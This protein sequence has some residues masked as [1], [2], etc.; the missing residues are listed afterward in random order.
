MRRRQF[1]GLS[2]LVAVWPIIA[3]A[4]QAKLPTVGFLVAGAPSSHARFVAAFV[5]RLHELGWTEGRTI[6]MEY[7]W[8]DGS[9]ERA[10]QLAAEF[11]RLKVDLIVTSGIATL[12][13][14][15]VIS[16]TPIVFAVVSDPVGLGLVS[17]LGRPGSNLTGLS[18]Q[19]TDL[20]GKRL[21]ILREVLP[22]LRRLGILA[23][24]G[25]PGPLL[26]IAEVEE[27]ARTLGLEIVAPDL[28]R[29]E[30]LAPAFAALKGRVDALYVVTDPLVNTHLVDISAMTVAARVPTLHGTREHVDAG[31]LLSYGPSL[32]DLYGRA[33]GYVDKILRGAKPGD[34][35]VQ[36]PTKFELV[37]NL[38]TAQ[39]PQ[40]HDSTH[41]PRPRRRGD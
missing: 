21:E 32:P 6:A 24:T 16:T 34:L 17:S 30:D 14:K 26:E 40:P 28:R 1:L 4:Q 25:N 10:A 9:R 13:A 22:G 11:D 36:Q 31:G 7:R 8:A 27:S 35:P 2:G 33:A 15:Q 29:S 5:R 37:I 3:D 12:A 18:L 23:N 20:A 19:Y 39:A 38:K 41:A